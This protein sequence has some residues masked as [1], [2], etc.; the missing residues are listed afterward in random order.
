M[1]AQANVFHFLPLS[2]LWSHAGITRQLFLDDQEHYVGKLLSYNTEEFVQ[3]W[4]LPE[5]T[6]QQLRQRLDS[7]KVTS[8]PAAAEIT[9]AAGG[10]T[11]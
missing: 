5:E 4:P 11:A 3:R 9:V 1:P 2:L 10:V 8:T 6:R 7:S